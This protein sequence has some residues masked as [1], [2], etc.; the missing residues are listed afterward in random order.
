MGLNELLDRLAALDEYG[1]AGSEKVNEKEVK[2]IDR[3]L[4]GWLMSLKPKDGK[5]KSKK[6]T[7]SK[8]AF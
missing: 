2:D 7:V 8:A 4:K 6:R 3:Q 1:V 5:E